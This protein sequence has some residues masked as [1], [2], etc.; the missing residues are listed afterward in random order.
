MTQDKLDQ[1]CVYTKTCPLLPQN[2]WD[3]Y[4]VVSGKERPATTQ[5]KMGRGQMTQFW[6]HVHARERWRGSWPLSPAKW[7]LGERDPVSFRPEG[8]YTHVH[9]KNVCQMLGGLIS[10]QRR[11]IRVEWSLHDCPSPWVQPRDTTPPPTASSRS[12]SFYEWGFSRAGTKSAFSSSPR[13]KKMSQTTVQTPWAVKGESSEPEV[14]GDLWGP[15]TV[16]GLFWRKH[17]LVSPT[18]FKD[19]SCISSPGI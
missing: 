8:K 15:A 4:W 14:S 3:I 18:G 2:D 16:R 11:E 19:L 6:G 7:D 12:F 17:F 10:A 9:G 5:S 1:V 13:E